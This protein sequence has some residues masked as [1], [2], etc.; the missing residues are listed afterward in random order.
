VETVADGTA[1]AGFGLTVSSFGATLEAMLRLSRIPI[2]DSVFRHRLMP[3]TATAI[4]T[5]VTTAKCRRE[6]GAIREACQGI[7][8]PANRVLPNECNGDVKLI[9]LEKVPTPTPV[10]V[11]SVCQAMRGSLRAVL[12][13]GR[14][15]TSRDIQKQR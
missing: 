10:I 4:M 6:V 13:G 12:R 2:A 7:R 8:H 3:Y 1:D 9:I 11:R 5:S 14:F 15:S